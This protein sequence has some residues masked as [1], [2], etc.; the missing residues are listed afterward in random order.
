[1]QRLREKQ[2]AGRTVE[3]YGQWVER[4][5]QW[6]AGKGVGLE[7][8]SGVELRSYLDMLA[9]DERVRVATQHQALNAVVRFFA[10]V[11]GRPV[12][13][14]EGYLRARSTDRVPVVLSQGEVGRLLEALEGTERVMGELMYGGGLRLMELL[15]L[16]VK[17]MDVERRQVV[18][19]GGKGDKDRVTTLAERT[20]EA[21]KGHLDRLRGLWE[22]DVKLGMPGVYVP[23][24]LG[25]K[26]PG[27]GRSLEWQWLFPTKGL[28]KD[29]ESGLDRRHHVHERLWQM[30]VKAAAERAGITKRVTP[31]VLRHSFATHL[32]ERGT[33]IRTVQSLLGHKDV[34]TTEVYTHV[35][36]RPGLGVRSPLD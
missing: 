2:Y 17:D 35:M 24:A 20:V 6:C 1:M 22:E 3:T 32:L 30:A 7:A 29:P 16:R 23:E 13:G 18:I 36:R 12:E 14:L 33:D 19:R 10:E 25:R 4:F 9:A 31:H 26:Y 34:K 5:Q 11:V 8:V 15:R 21:V 27:A 28:V